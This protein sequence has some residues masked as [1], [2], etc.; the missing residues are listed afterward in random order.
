MSSGSPPSGRMRNT[1]PLQIV[2]PLMICPGREGVPNGRNAPVST[3]PW[4]C[5]KSFVATKDFLQHHGKV[6]TGAF[7]PFGTPSRPGQIIKGQTICS[8]SVLRIRPEG[9]EPELIAWGLRNPFGL[10]FLGQQLFVTDNGYD[11]RGSRPIWGAPDFLWKIEKGAWYGWPD[12][13]GGVIFSM[14]M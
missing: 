3:L 1:D 8:G 12:F 5:R 11:Q 6:E 7:L 14:T 9:G 13:C 2:W 10:A 4:C